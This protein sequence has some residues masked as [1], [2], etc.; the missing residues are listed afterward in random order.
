MNPLNNITEDNTL[1]DVLF[2]ID[3]QKGKE[4]YSGGRLICGAHPPFDWHSFAEIPPDEQE[5][6][7]QLLSGFLET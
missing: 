4:V 6:N 7:S 2:A 5:S 3:T 1:N